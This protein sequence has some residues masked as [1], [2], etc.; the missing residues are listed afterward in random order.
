MSDSET[1]KTATET[2]DE[3]RRW[4]YG[5]DSAKAS[6]A[7]LAALAST[8]DLR[9][10]YDPKSGIAKPIPLESDDPIAELRGAIHCGDDTMRAMQLMLV[11]LIG[12]TDAEEARA[13]EYLFASLTDHEL[14]RA[15]LWRGEVGD[16]FE[17]VAATSF[18]RG[19]ISGFGRLSVGGVTLL[20]SD[21]RELPARPLDGIAVPLELER[22]ALNR[23]ALELER[24]AFA[25]ELALQLGTGYALS[26]E[27][28]IFVEP[29]AARFVANSVRALVWH[30]DWLSGRAP[31]AAL[32]NLLS[33]ASLL[34]ELDRLVELPAILDALI[35]ST[36]GDSLMK[37]MRLVERTGGVS[38]RNAVDLAFTARIIGAIRRGELAPWDI[39]TSDA[40]KVLDKA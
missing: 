19:K 21:L 18:L 10:Q 30:A 2:F 3:A 26:L 31:F 38:M 20:S 9:K 11:E 4:R 39:D 12:L 22:T 34:Y 7:G 16:D 24:L 13:R 33:G 28:H 8:I 1:T 17:A 29:S 32:G 27:G 15:A 36:K 40:L 35:K 5:V 25:V 23:T 37:L 6:A 14:A